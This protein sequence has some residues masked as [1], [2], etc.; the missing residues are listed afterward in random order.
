MK[1]RK[2][3]VGKLYALP[4]PY[5]RYSA[6]LLRSGRLRIYGPRGPLTPSRINKESDYFHLSLYGEENGERVRIDPSE[7]HVAFAIATRSWKFYRSIRR[8]RREIDHRDRNTLNNDPANLRLVRHERQARNRDVAV[9]TD[10]KKLK[11]MAQMRAGG[12]K[13]REIGEVFNC[14]LSTVQLALTG[15]SNRDLL[16]KLDVAVDAGRNK[17][18]LTRKSYDAIFDMTLKR[19]SQTQIADKIS[20]SRA[21]VQGCLSG[22]YYTEWYNEIPNSVKA[23]IAAIKVENVVS[24]RKFHRNE[25]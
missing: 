15:K 4:A 20:I 22:K 23:K 25:K 9:V 3:K 8:G 19:R 1:K 12:A 14:H 18:R 11:A 10:V 21:Q 2:I 5:D 24:G 6:K 16:E 17:K 7:H 13:Y